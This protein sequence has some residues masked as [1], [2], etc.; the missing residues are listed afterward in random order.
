MS[1]YNSNWLGIEAPEPLPIQEWR[2]TSSI[3]YTPSEAD[4][5]AVAEEEVFTVIGLKAQGIIP[6]TTEELVELTVGKTL[7]TRNLVIVQEAKVHYGE[8][9]IRTI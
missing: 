6:L 7:T 1:T 9:V 4:L 2:W 5:Q 8:D 3:C